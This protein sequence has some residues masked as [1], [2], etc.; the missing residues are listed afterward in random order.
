M[1]NQ[2]I[3]DRYRKAGWKIVVTEENYS[4]VDNY[5]YYVE[6]YPIGYS[7]SMDEEQIM[8]LPWGYELIGSEYTNKEDMEKS[9]A[10]KL[11]KFDIDT[12]KPYYFNKK[13]NL[14]GGQYTEGKCPFCEKSNCNSSIIDGDGATQV[15]ITKGN[16][17]TAYGSIL[18]VCTQL[19]AYCPICGRK[20]EGDIHAD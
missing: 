5:R 10:L 1:T 11:K 6:I 12:G 8:S 13:L 4:N 17:L 16:Q 14:L 20:L 2:Q 19:I 15:Y 9:I 3:I 18:G 7:L